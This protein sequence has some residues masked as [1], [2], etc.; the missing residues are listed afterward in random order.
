[1]Y[2]LAGFKLLSQLLLRCC[3]LPAAQDVGDSSQLV[4]ERIEGLP[5]AESGAPM[6]APYPSPA[7]TLPVTT[8]QVDVAA[9]RARTES[10][11]QKPGLSRWDLWAFAEGELPLKA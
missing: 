10:T 11:V 9:S 7:A 8:A 1:M 5:Q 4:H 3:R 6:E 2:S